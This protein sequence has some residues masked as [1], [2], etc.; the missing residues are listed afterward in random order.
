[1]RTLLALM[2][3]TIPALAEMPPK[4]YEHAY[5]GELVE[6]Q[7]SLGSAHA[8]CNWLARQLGEPPSHPMK[9]E[10]RPLYG[11]AYVYEKQCF[12]V[13]SFS[14]SEHRMRSNVRR[15]E[16]AHCNGWPANHKGGH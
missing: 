6:W 16:I 1:M 13:Y 15:H 9:V 11:C 5:K 7:V 10:G 12:I 2:L 4:K 3:S 14:P 8:Q